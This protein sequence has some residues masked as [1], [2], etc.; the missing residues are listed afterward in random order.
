MATATEAVDVLDDIEKAVTA[1]FGYMS[2]EAAAARFQAAVQIY[3]TSL[4]IDQIDR[5]IDS[6]RSRS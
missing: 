6:W 1:K 5:F 3:N 4:I 2:D